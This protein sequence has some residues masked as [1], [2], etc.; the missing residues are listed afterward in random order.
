M[1]LK[2][3]TQVAMTWL[4]EQFPLAFFQKSH[5]VKPLKLGIIEDIVDVY[6]RLDAPPFSKKRLREAINY[7]TSSRAYLTAQQANAVRVDLY[8]QQYGTVSAEQAIYAQQRFQQRYSA[9]R[10]TIK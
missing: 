9:E 10:S 2:I 7:Y 6:E 4:V 5:L 3:E 8:G 1:A